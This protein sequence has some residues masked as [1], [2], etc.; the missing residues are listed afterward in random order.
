M[1]ETLRRAGAADAE[2]LALLGGATFLNAFAHDHP[3]DALVAHVARYHAPEWYR[4]TLADPACAVWI[5]ETA[6]GA[7]V[8]YAVMTPPDLNHATAPGDLELKRIYVLT[9]WQKDGWGAKLLHAVQAEARARGAER[10]LLCV[11]TANDRAQ[12]FYA[13]EGF[14][15]TGSMQSFFVGD[16]PFEDM[17][18]AKAL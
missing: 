8:A 17:I 11:Y 3:G 15:D 1:T 13:R 16:V 18:W 6:L 10:L 2:R 12:R 4:R 9:G 5:V 7:P 14:A